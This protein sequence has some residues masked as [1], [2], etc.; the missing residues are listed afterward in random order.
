MNILLLTPSELK[1]FQLKHYSERLANATT[2]KAKRF[3]R[4]ELY[5]LK[6][7]QT[8]AEAENCNRPVFSY[9]RSNRRLDR[10]Q[11]NSHQ[12]CGERTGGFS[13]INR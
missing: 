12:I 11:K 4:S 5:N 2:T 1:E 7:P 10:L 9:R 3:L 13:R 8:N 6:K